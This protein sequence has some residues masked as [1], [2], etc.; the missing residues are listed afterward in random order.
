MK[1][2]SESV[3]HYSTAIV[4]A[5]QV[6]NDRYCKLALEATLVA[7]RARPGQFVML[8]LPSQYGPMLPRPFSIFAVERD[9]GSI[10][11]LFET[12][13]RG[14]A[15]AA[16]LDAGQD[17]KLLGPLGSYFPEPQPGALLLAGGLGIAPL[18]FLAKSTTVPITLV[19]AVQKADHLAC[20]P[21]DLSRPGLKLLLATE[22]GSAGFKGS[23]INL[24]SNQ[25]EQASALYSCGP[26]KMLSKAA[27]A[28]AKAGVQCFIS[29]E[30]RMACG[31]GAC[32]GCAV[33][34][35]QGYKRVCSDGPVFQAGEVILNGKT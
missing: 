31:V 32:L 18:A 25:L 2:E 34:T 17:L 1:K 6:V 28:A 27:S 7:A 5:K 3:K 13:G 21:E 12:R 11:L 33:K 14:T 4:A 20:Q 24:L 35:G 15:L 9:K 22:D 26:R 29:L 19:Y 23:A 16:G 10:T 30:E 8:Y